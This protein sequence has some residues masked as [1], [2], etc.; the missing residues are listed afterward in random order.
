MGSSQG[1]TC[2][3]DAPTEKAPSKEPG[4]SRQGRRKNAYLKP[5][6]R[7]KNPYLAMLKF[8]GKRKKAYHVSATCEQ[9][10]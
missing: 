5:H 9:K 7:E 3:P 8:H 1:L 6:G 2:S 10:L 4:P